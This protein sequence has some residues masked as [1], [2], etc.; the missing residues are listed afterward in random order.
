MKK[1]Y[2]K[3]LP[4]LEKLAKATSKER[5][6]ILKTSSPK[7]IQVI[8]DIIFNVLKGHLRLVDHHYKKLRPYKRTLLLLANRS[9]SANVKREALLKKK[10]GFLPV[11]LPPIIAGLATVALDKIVD[12]VNG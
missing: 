3:F 2:K 7:L 10:G 12:A 11:I 4:E 5:L 9:K 6:H 1:L 8:G